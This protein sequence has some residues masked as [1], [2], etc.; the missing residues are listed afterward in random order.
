MGT[1]KER[2]YLE[3]ANFF[4]RK[5]ANDLAQ[6][7]I[8]VDLFMFPN[9]YIDVASIGNVC[10][11]TGGNLY[12]YINFQQQR[13]GARFINDLYRGL[14]RTFAY[15]ALLRIRASNGLFDLCRFDCEVLN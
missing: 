7:G 10:A 2:Q 11:V 14:I 9:A 6:A 13:D 8:C 1:D 5:S 4:W 12:L 3:P 15:D